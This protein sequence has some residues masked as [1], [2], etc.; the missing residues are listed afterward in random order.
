MRGIKKNAIGRT[1]L[2][3]FGGE[4][5]WKENGARELPLVCWLLHIGW[6]VALLPFVAIIWQATV[7]RS[8]LVIT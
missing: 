8:L 5:G 6:G 7:H 4:R 1:A 2:N 3:Y